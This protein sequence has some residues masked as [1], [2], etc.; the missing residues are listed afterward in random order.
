MAVDAPVAEMPAQADRLRRQAVRGGSLLLAAR[1]GARLFQWS[2]TLFVTRLL[3][4]DDYGMMTAGVL[5]VGLA[6]MLAEAGI[7]KA[8][9]HRKTLTAADTAQTFTLS[10]ML[11]A[12]LYAVLWGI[13]EPAAVLQQKPE[14][15][16]F[17]RVLGLL[18]FLVPFRS[19]AGARLERGLML[20]RQSVVQ[21]TVGVGQ[22]VLVLALAFA[23]LGYWALAAGTLTSRLLEAGCLWYASGWRPSLALP[24]RQAWDLLRY[25][26]H[27]SGATLLW[28]V[29]NNS[30]FAAIDTFHGA[31]VL[32]SYA[33]AFQLMTLP[34][35]KLSAHVNQIMFS[36][37]CRIQDDRARVR[38]WFLRVTVLLTFVIAPALVGL[39][40]VAADGIPLL[41]GE[42]WAPAVLPFQ[43]LC[44]V[45]VIMVVS[46]ALHQMFAA[47]GRPDLTLKNNI[48]CAAILP[49]GFFAAAAFFGTVGVCI[50]WLV[51]TPI[52]VAVL[53]QLTRGVTGIG[54]VDVLRAQLPVLAGVAVMTGGVLALQWH[55]RDDPRVAVRLVAAIA[56]GIATYAGWM[57]LTA[58]RTVLAD[59]RSLWLELRGR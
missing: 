34:V 22:S 59:L 51:L 16:A 49:A 58:R 36:V 5:F 3:L 4:P 17:L 6:D 24:G 2:A 13:A 37:F 8:L 53:L 39:A 31:V 40:L 26:L 35:Q 57:L 54:V 43:L 25:G 47:L 45:G 28:F 56:T 10:L 50:V 32:G 55:L 29:Y 19:V 48:V 27:V 18:L 38:D 20:G 44:P 14:F 33:V 41:L 15:A 12:A 46:S 1:L 7:G 42:R 9:V 30:D 21:L 23:G 52:M 11:A